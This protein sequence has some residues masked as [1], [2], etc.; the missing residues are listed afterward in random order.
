MN[1]SK[2]LGVR[3]MDR[4]ESRASPSLTI[5]LQSFLITIRHDKCLIEAKKKIVEIGAIKND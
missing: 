2:F 5:F 4:F 3:M 1:L